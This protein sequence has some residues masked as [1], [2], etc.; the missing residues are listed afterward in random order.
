MRGN[1]WEWIEDWY[2]LYDPKENV[3]PVSSGSGR[4]RIIRGG[5]WWSPA[6]ITTCSH[7]GNLAPDYKAIILGFRLVRE[8][9]N[10]A[11][12]AGP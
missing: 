2:A 5:S 11:E 1:V 10:P 4:A 12:E 9:K 7:R 8:I 3:D 6:E